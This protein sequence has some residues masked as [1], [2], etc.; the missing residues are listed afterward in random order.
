MFSE[1]EYEPH[2][3]D[4]P[5][6]F[7]AQNPPAKSRQPRN[8]LHSHQ[9]QLYPK[10]TTKSLCLFSFQF[11]YPTSN[12]L[13]EAVLP[14]KTA[15]SPQKTSLSSGNAVHQENH[16]LQDLIRSDGY[17]TGYS[18]RQ[19]PDVRFGFVHSANEYPCQKTYYLQTLYRQIKRPPAKYQKAAAQ[20]SS[21]Q[22][23]RYPHKHRFPVPPIRNP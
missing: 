22:R 2:I 8:A 7:D 23:L 1:S 20:Y 3:S 13:Q 5:A 12:D 15:H 18:G 19:T 10:Y 6:T 16:R 4:S 17:T 9:K 14:A 21:W 11:Q